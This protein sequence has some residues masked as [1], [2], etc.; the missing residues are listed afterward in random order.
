M[1]VQAGKA[2]GTRLLWP[3]TSAVRPMTDRVR[4][5]LFS[6]LGDRL[7]R[8]RFLDLFAGSGCL[9][10][11][12]LSRGAAAAVFVE[13]R[14]AVAE[15]IQK[16]LDRTHLDALARVLTTD[17]LRI[18]RALPEQFDIICLDPPYAMSR[19]LSSDRPVTQLIRQ[20]GDRMLAPDGILML[21]HSSHGSSPEGIGSL[22]RTDHRTYGSRAL[23]F[24]QLAPDPEAS[25]QPAESSSPNSGGE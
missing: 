1:R 2:K 18:A 10:I 8:A 22:V 15:I 20:L 4:M 13:K 19:T 16:N 3:R 23:S 21:G 11:E 25:H 7:P 12:A 17:A 14:R 6:I 5:S 24:Y 9:G